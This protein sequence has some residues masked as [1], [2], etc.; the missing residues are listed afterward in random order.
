MRTAWKQ[1]LAR[2]LG[3]SGRRS[4]PLGCNEEDRR[5]LEVAMRTCEICGL[6]LLPGEKR[7]P[8]AIAHLDCLIDLE[9]QID[10][11]HDADAGRPWL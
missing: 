3:E 1:A 11:E 10:Q 4:A 6:E 5:D 7:A 8:G 2:L 9:H